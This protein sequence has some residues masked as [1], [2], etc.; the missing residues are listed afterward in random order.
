MTRDE[1]R[2]IGAILGFPSCCVERWIE[3]LSSDDIL[4]N[5]TG[6]IIERERPLLEALACSVGASS[7]L[8]RLWGLVTGFHSPSDLL[9]QYVPCEDCRLSAGLPLDGSDRVL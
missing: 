7:V 8:G 4:A 3:S 1:H 5:R 6:T 9:K 2:Q